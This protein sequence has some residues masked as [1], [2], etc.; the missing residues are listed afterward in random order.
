MADLAP[1]FRVVGVALFW[2]QTLAGV[3]WIWFRAEV[4]VA[5]VVYYYSPWERAYSDRCY[6]RICCGV[7]HGDCSADTVGGVQL[8]GVAV[9]C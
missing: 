1:F 4:G 6:Y 5:L 2:G 9:H 8:A 3:G 7:D